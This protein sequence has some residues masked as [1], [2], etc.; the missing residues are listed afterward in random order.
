LDSSPNS[1]SSPRDRSTKCPQT[2]LPVCLSCL[3]ICLSKIPQNEIL[4]PRFRVLASSFI[5]SLVYSVPEPPLSPIKKTWLILDIEP[6]TPY[7]LGNHSTLNY[8]P[9][10]NRHL[11]V[12]AWQDCIRANSFPVLR[13]SL[14]TPFS[15][16]PNRGLNSKV[17]RCQACSVL[18]KGPLIGEKRGALTPDLPSY[19]QTGIH[20]L[21]DLQGPACSDIHCGCLKR[22]TA[23]PTW[24]PG[25]RAGCGRWRSPAPAES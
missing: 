16:N 10:T 18:Q 12:F 5:L 24:R 17:Q 21:S 15:A 3:S 13:C 1:A 14:H 2:C 19:I 4:V 25:P 6:R 23:E 20:P 7:R 22:A 11:K 9:S 8:T